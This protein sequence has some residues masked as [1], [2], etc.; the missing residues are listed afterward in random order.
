MNIG[1]QSGRA[2]GPDRETFELIQQHHHADLELHSLLKETR[3]RAGSRAMPAALPKSPATARQAR[4]FQIVTPV[5]NGAHYLDET[6]GSVLQQAGNFTINYHI[7]DG[8][9]SDATLAIARS[10]QRR[11]QTGELP[12]R[13]NRIRL[14]IDSRPD[15]GMYDA[16]A[17]GFRLLAP[18]R[19]DLMTWINSD[20][21]LAAGALDAVTGALEDLPHFDLVGGRH[22]L[23]DAE[24]QSLGSFDIITY[25]IEC[26]AAGLNDGRHLPF[27][28]QE[29]TFW[30]AELWDEVGGVDTRFKLAGDW[31]LWRRFAARAAYL[32]LDA[33]T[34]YHR[35]RAG[36]LSEDLSAYYREVEDRLAE[37]MS[38]RDSAY[39]DYRH[40]WKHQNSW[41]RPSQSARFAARVAQLGESG[42]WV[43]VEG[44]PPKPLM[45][46]APSRG[47]RFLER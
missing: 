22:A 23:I 6:I 33:V 29:G 16:V 25:P 31:D 13:C 1:P 47:A 40:W 38:G 46:T 14:T 15:S 17:A 2:S 44:K 36:Q 26:V 21:L 45:R 42:K 34:A 30:R 32:T 27:I 39:R 12:L 4:V 35:R 9:S 20:D 3:G 18:A 43:S 7:Q 41:W 8:G 37:E 28:M 10:W 19:G 5:R 24:G 11:L